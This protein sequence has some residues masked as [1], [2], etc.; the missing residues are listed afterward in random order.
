MRE[1]LRKYRPLL[2]GTCLV[3]AALLLYSNNLR[4]KDH[5]SVFEQMA[6][7]VTAPLLK[8]IDQLVAQ[9]Q[10]LWGNYVWL[11]EAAQENAQLR[12]ENFLLKAELENL[13]EIRLANERLRQLLEFKDELVLSA[14]PARVIAV[15]A[16]SWSRTVLL[17]K[18]TR[19]GVREGMAV[20]T[21]AGV[22]GR[23]IKAAPGESRVLLITDAAS[24]VA[25]LVQRT[26]TRGVCRGRGD[27]LTLDFALR[28]EDIQVGDRLVTSGTGGVFP[29]GLLVGEVVRVTRGDYG[30]FQTVEVAPAADFSRL[31]EVLVLVEEQP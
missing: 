25:T 24:A 1:L 28:Q 11:V 21:A 17:D 3:L 6:L 14:V 20:V 9:T 4:R 7:I 16:S 15:D 10:A 23:V 8:G 22:V 31:E 12:E 30:L 13:R 19:S 27:M 5:T 2:L 29:K 26:R 18:G